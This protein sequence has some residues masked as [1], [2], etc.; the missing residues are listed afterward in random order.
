MNCAGNDRHAHGAGELRDAL[1]RIP[2]FAGLPAPQLRDLA[3]ASRRLELAKE[4]TLFRVGEPARE[5]F[6]LLSGQAKRAT[7][8]VGGNEKV[9]E[10]LLPGQAFG[11]AELFG[12]QN[13]ASF[14]VA[15]EPTVLLCVGGD[16]VRRALASEP[17]LALRLIGALARRA[18]AIEGDA[19]ASH[20][21]TGCQRVL[22]YLLAQVDSP[23]A[24]EGQTTLTLPASKQLIASRIGMTPETLSRVLRELTD[25]GMIIVDGRDIHLQNAR[26][27][28]RLAETVPEQPVFPRRNS[29]R[30][31]GRTAR[32]AAV[33]RLG[34]AI[35]IAGRQRMLSQRMAKSWLL[36]GRGIQPT[37][38]RSILTQS[39]RLFEQQMATLAG[40]PASD[41]IRRA[42]A[43]LADVWQAYRALL[44]DEPAAPRARELFE[45]NETVLAAAHA[46]T[47]AYEN[48]AGTNQ[49]R[50]IN[51]AGRQR[52]LSQRM[53]MF[54][55]FQQWG[56][57]VARSRAGLA[58]ATQEFAAA[59]ARLAAAAGQVPRIESQLELVSQHWQ[60][61][62]S[63]LAAPAPADPRRQA[64]LVSVTSERL[65][66]QMDL[67]VSLY[68]V[69]PE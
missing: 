69:L 21:R 55:L 28:R 25:A 44:A 33:P 54:Y 66:R 16:S 68:E 41:E 23:L 62:Q 51:L 43:R 39:T 65:L 26:I 14:A 37:R 6:F 67:A 15:V 3:R 45:L 47:L 18:I 11:E 19:T 12:E 59:Q 58:A 34:A 60:L 56:V 40:L 53:A 48:E 64:G 17:R 49:G 57:H 22:D 10:L 46:M 31:H 63:A 13:Y 61:L 2:L 4:Q 42:Q 7:F 36:L 27:V 52:M 1:T 5:L 30:D 8:S 32:R 50:L 20:F 24:T 9:L 29:H 38:S 35:N